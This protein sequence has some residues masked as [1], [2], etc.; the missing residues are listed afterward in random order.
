MYGPTKKAIGETEGASD[1]Y[2]DNVTLLIQSNNEPDGST[3]FVDYS[4]YGHTVNTT[5]GAPT[6]STAQAIFG[7]S[8]IDLYT[9]KAIGAVDT[10]SS[11]PADFTLE[12]WFYCQ[13]VPASGTGFSYVLFS[14]AAK[15][16]IYPA[17]TQGIR[18][19]GTEFINGVPVFPSQQWS[20][21]ALTREG[22]TLRYF[23]N[24]VQLGTGTYS[25]T[26][27]FTNMNLGR[28]VPNN[29]AAFN[30]YVDQFRLTKDVARYTENFT[31][32]TQAFPTS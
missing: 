17:P 27:N 19:N 9:S 11:F 2:W 18:I 30:G 22:S 1:T 15:T 26:A 10:D 32:P 20:H 12:A 28:Y 6:H 7:S 24:G 14:N 8:S 21:L 23:V 4:S 16:Y 3:N 25:G 13:G 31:P 29:N 5:K